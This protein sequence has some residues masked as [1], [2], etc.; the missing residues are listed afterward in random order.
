[1]LGHLKSVNCEHVRTRQTGAHIE[2]VLHRS[3]V[4]VSEW[5]I[6]V[7]IRM[8]HDTTAVSIV[9]HRASLQILGVVFIII[10]IR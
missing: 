2:C 1:M 8:N 5:T 4:V 7:R 10:I 6:M 9:I 3:P